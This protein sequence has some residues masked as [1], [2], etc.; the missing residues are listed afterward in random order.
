MRSSSALPLFG[1][2]SILAVPLLHDGKAIAGAIAVGATNP[3]FISDRADRAPANVRDQ[4]VIAIENARLF[5]ETKEALERQTATSEILRA[6]ASRRRTGSRVRQ[7]SFAAADE[8][9]AAPVRRTFFTFD[10][11]LIRFGE[12]LV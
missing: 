6:S 10:G 3:G 4:A 5:N 12:Q 2:R 9:L 8:A 11:M 1:F 7:P